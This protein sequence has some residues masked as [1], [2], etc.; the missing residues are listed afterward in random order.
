MAEKQ[1]LGKA[2]RL[3]TGEQEFFGLFLLLTD[4]LGGQRHRD[5]SRLGRVEQLDK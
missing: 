1:R 3:R 2:H 4:L 5:T